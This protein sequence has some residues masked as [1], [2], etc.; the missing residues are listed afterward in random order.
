MDEY[1]ATVAKIEA[2]LD[3]SGCDC[4]CCDENQYIW[5]QN[6]SPAA[7]IIMQEIAALQDDVATLQG[8]VAT[9]Q[10]DSIFTAN[11]GLTKAGNNVAL[12]GTLIDET[13][14]LL[15]GNELHFVPTTTNSFLI[16]SSA[17]N[18]VQINTTTGVA[19]TFENKSTTNTIQNVLQIL[20]TNSAGAGGNGIGTQLSFAA[21]KSNSTNGNTSVIKSSWVDATAGDSK[22]EIGVTEANVNSTALTIKSDGELQLNNYGSGTFTGTA[23]YNLAVDA[24]GNVIEV[25]GGGG[26]PLVYIARVSQTGSSAPTAVEIVNTTGATFTWARVLAGIYTVTASSAVFTTDKT[27]IFV[28]SAGPQPYISRAAVNSTTQ[29]GVNTSSAFSGTQDGLM[30]DSYVKIEIYP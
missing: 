1:R 17:S 14:I 26:G 18:A 7:S 4:G 29:C 16:E 19:A 23:T 13:F 3:A 8:D 10:V 5:V 22:F 6:T 24:S 25:A 9:L 28:T 30:T 21:E 15:D 2:Q 11:N 12:G 27:A 20:T